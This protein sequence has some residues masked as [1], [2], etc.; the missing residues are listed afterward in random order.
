[1]GVPNLMSHDFVLVRRGG[2][3]VS[4]LRDVKNP[5]GVEVGVLR[6][7]LSACVLRE[8]PELT[9]HMVDPW[10]PPEPD[11]S[12]AKSGD[13][14]SMLSD[15]EFEEI[16]KQAMGR[17]DFAANRR[18][19]HRTTSVH[20]AETWQGDRVDMVFID[21]DHSDE[22]VVEDVVSWWPIVKEG[23]WIGGHD[24]RT[25][26][27][28]RGYHVGLAVLRGMKHMGVEP[29]VELGEDRTWFI[30]KEAA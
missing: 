30:R 19:V 15:Y 13:S 17:T 23:G 11:S 22:G 26:G 12:Y 7:C 20:C 18:V 25:P 1:M 8:L 29:E 16:R 5:V 4:R 2:E 3:V 9:W 10:W 6:G 21:A 24:W 27:K 28:A 14:V